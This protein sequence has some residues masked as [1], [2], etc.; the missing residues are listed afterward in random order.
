MQVGA[1]M[2]AL[3][4]SCKKSVLGQSLF[5]G[6]VS[7]LQNIFIQVHDSRVAEQKIEIL[8]CLR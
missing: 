7:H 4:Y 8:Q 6:Y 5:T 3:R 2:D 1:G